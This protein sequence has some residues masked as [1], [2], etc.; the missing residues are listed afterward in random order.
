LT[1]KRWLI[2]LGAVALALAIT[3]LAIDPSTTREG[4]PSIVDLEFAWDRAGVERLVFGGGPDWVDAAERSLRIDFLYL[5]AYGI[6][7]A[8]AA[9]ATRDL[10]AE[11]GWLRMSRLGPVA[12]W[13]AIGGALFDAVE[14]VFLLIA[15]EGQGDDTAPFLGSV[16]ACGKF[17]LLSLAILYL[18][19]GL[20]LRLRDRLT[21]RPA[22]AAG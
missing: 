13:C 1:R 10:A 2:A 22:R 6:F 7:L 8:L 3:L 20:A 11:R 4:A 16:F 17:A 15:L 5:L 21:R 19:A 9:A 14:D 12:V 18:L